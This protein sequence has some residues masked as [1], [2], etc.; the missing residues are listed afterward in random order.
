MST[1]FRIS[2]EAHSPEDLD[3][4]I[5]EL[6][7]Y[8]LELDP[9]FGRM[10]IGVGQETWSMPGLSSREKALLC[11]ANDI[12]YQH[13]GLPLRMHVDMALANAV[14]RQ[15]LREVVRHMA[16]YA[17]YPACVEARV[18]LAEIEAN[19]EER[20]KHPAGEE[21]AY[22]APQPFAFPS[23]Q[24]ATLRY[25]DAPY[26]DFVVRQAEQVWNRPHLSH[27]ERA[28]LSLASDVCHQ[29]LDESFRLH[30][31]LALESGASQEQVR[32]VLR[33]LAEF[34]M[35]KAWRAFQELAKYLSST[36]ALGSEVQHAEA[37]PSRPA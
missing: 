1:N 9:E 2:P 21:T 6:S 31:D 35:A 30:V 32:A 19:L 15:D 20:A 26:A 23:A 11:L 29:T 3:S 13:L 24:S 33:F 22:P 27:L 16:P 4:A 14:S 5:A 17:G 34:S 28:Y 25:L 36:E 12:L 18:R 8:I 10:S 7:T 37:P